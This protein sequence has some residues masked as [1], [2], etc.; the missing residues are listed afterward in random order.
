MAIKKLRMFL[1]AA[2]IGVFAYGSAYSFTSQLLI[3]GFEFF[4][5]LNLTN[6]D[7][8]TI[9]ALY[10]V[11]AGRVAVITDVYIALSSGAQG[12]HTTFITNELLETKAGPFRTTP[13]AAFSKNYTSGITWTEGRQIIAS[14]T[15]GSGDVTV[16][17]VGYLVCP[18]SCD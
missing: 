2:T 4:G 10:T 14:D 3:D 13:E 6:S 8:G 12:A 9:T 17:L 18:G 16:N 5:P 1:A 7:V 11:P 15:G